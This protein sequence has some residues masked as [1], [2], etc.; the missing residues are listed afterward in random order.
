M[1]FWWQGAEWDERK[2]MDFGKP[3]AGHFRRVPLTTE[4]E[5]VRTKNGALR[6]V[7]R[8]AHPH[9][10]MRIYCGERQRARC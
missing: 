9:T 1:K 8:N 7:L 5:M 3:K 10:A 6:L 4:P 2:P